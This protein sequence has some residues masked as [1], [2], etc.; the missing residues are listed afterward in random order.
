[1]IRIN[2]LP[3]EIIEKRKWERYY[4]LVFIVAGILIAIV[5]AAW[6]ILQFTAA[7][8]RSELQA[9]QETSAQL[10][11]QADSLAVFELSKG[12]LA[13]RQAAADSALA[14][15]IDMGRLAEEI[16]LVLPEAVWINSYSC[17]QKE[18]LAIVANAPSPFGMQA[19]QGYKAAAMT[20]VRLGSLGAVSDV[21]L[22]DA[23][24]QNFSSFQ[25]LPSGSVNA[26]AAIL[27]FAVSADVT[28][29]A[30]W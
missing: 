15:R 16:S 27:L 17:T 13:R 9:I 20:V 5:V 22:S 26:S 19:D 30:G 18:G 24:A 2:L 8:K 21:W 4:P 10:Q 14:G 6:A 25:G 7:N 29:T 28:S 3:P 12:E 23:T 11:Q 1:M